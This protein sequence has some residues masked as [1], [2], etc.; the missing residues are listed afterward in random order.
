MRF[1]FL[2]ILFF[3]S[4]LG[5]AQKAQKYLGDLPVTLSQNIKKVTLER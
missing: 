3:I 5:F 2:A 4:S 1:Y